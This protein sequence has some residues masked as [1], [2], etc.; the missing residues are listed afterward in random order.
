[1]SVWFII[2][3]CLKCHPSPRHIPSRSR[4][5][6]TFQTKG[7]FVLQLDFWTYPTSVGTPVDIHVRHR[8]FLELKHLLKSKNIAFS[9]KISNL[10]RLIDEERTRFRSASF[11]SK[12]HVYDQVSTFS[13]LAT[14]RYHEQ[15]IW[16]PEKKKRRKRR[17]T[18]TPSDLL[19]PRDVW[20]LIYSVYMC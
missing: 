2:W 16:T 11:D 17:K 7:H 13:N 6:R 10:Q 18:F 8:R 20:V 9:L 5:R 4:R 19:G 1:M 14:N 12:Y 3:H 15:T